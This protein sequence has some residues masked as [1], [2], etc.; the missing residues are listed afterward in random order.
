MTSTSSGG[1]PSSWA[2][3][4][5]NVVSCP[6]P[7]VCTESRSCGLARRVDA[8]L[9]A[10]GHAQPEDVHVLRGPAPT[11]S[12]KNADADAH[13]LAARRRACSACSAPQLLVAGDLHRQPQRPRVVAGVVLPAG[14]RDVRELLRLDQVLQ[15]QLGGIH[16]ELVGEAV[17]HPLDQVHRL[18]D[19]ERA[20]VGD[21]A[22]R[23][24]GVDAGDLAVRGRVV[25]R[26]GEHV[27]EPG[28]DS[29]SAGP[30]R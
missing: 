16:A 17:D 29:W 19:A 7:W 30:W 13:Q 26:A 1:M 25:V 4:W 10:V 12:V 24:V 28:R 21:A 15:P 18:G 9:A 8:Q 11:P 27:E 14:R 6:W 3:I 22:R 20:G 23:L 5:A 2:T